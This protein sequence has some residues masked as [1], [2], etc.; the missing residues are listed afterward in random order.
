MDLDKEVEKIYGKTNVDRVTELKKIFG[1]NSKKEKNKG[2]LICNSCS[3]YY[4]LKYGES[5][6][7]FKGC[8][9]GNPL[10]YKEDFNPQ[11][12]SQISSYTDQF[13][14]TYRPDYKNNTPTYFNEDYF[15]EY[16]ELQQIVDIIKIKA[17]E[18]KKFME[19]LYESI[20]KQEKILN[21]INDEQILEVRNNKWSLWGLIEEKNIKNDLNNQKMIVDDVLDKENRLLS[22]VKDKREKKNINAYHAN[23]NSYAKIGILTLIIAFLSIIAI[24]AIK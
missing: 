11:K 16:A 14:S 10:E 18:R 23:I 2:Y 24:Y 13:N 9:C 4:K 3:G 12:K 1:K 8:E 17:E 7:D 19:N 20:Q 15:D 22:Y 6:D 5:P 21:S